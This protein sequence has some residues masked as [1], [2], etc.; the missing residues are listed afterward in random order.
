ML[1][2]SGW[3]Q[4][5]V[6]P[7]IKLTLVTVSLVGAGTS[8][9]AMLTQCLH[10]CGQYPAWW[11]CHPTPLLLVELS[12]MLTMSQVMV[13]LFLASPMVSG[14]MDM[15]GSIMLLV[16]LGLLMVSFT[17]VG[18][19]YKKEKEIA[20]EK[21]MEYETVLVD[22]DDDDNSSNIDSDNEGEQRQRRRKIFC[23]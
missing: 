15:Q 8:A 22:Q 5:G 13:M 14:L 2:V 19:H 4:P 20:E 17:M 1:P 16:Y 18:N 3:F 10:S 6:Y 21:M 23:V 7:V 12:I 9:L 11:L